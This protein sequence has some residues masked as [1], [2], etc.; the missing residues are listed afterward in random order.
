[1]ATKTLIKVPLRI[2]ENGDPGCVVAPDGMGRELV[3][4]TDQDKEL[5][6]KVPKEKVGTSL[7]AA[8]ADFSVI[9]FFKDDNIGFYQHSLFQDEVNLS[10]LPLLGIRGETW[11]GVISFASERFQPIYWRAVK[12][13]DNPVFLRGGEVEHSE[14]IYA[15]SRSVAG[16]EIRIGLPIEMGHDD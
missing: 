16:W 3:V 8:L 11:L 2:K 10:L 5:K 14:R 13:W 6:V 1:M 15:E 4:V 9:E 12:T 7:E